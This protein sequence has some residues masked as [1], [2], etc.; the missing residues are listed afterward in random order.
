MFT[1]ASALGS[2]VVGVAI[3]TPLGISGTLAVL[4][5]LTLVPAA[6]WT[7]WLATWKGNREEA[8]R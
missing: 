7:V 1:L 3:D 4:A 8:G 5:A 6:A 2:A